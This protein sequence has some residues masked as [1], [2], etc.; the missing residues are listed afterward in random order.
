LYWIRSC[1]GAWIVGGKSVLIV[2]RQEEAE[3]GFKKAFELNPIFLVTVHCWGFLYLAQGRA[4]NALAEIERRTV[5]G[6]AFA[7]VTQFMYHALGRKKES[8][9]ALSELIAKIRE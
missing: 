2:G 4:Q 6:L 5:C 3:M 7:K 1:S 9:T 8:D